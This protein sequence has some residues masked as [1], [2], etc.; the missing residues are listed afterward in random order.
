LSVINSEGHP[1]GGG[2]LYLLEVVRLPNRILK[3]SIRSSETIN[4]LTWEEEACFYRLMTACDDYGCFD[5][6]ASVVRSAL[7]P[8]RVDWVTEA[9]VE[10]WLQRMVQV[11]LLQL[12]EVNGRRYLRLV[13]WDSH[14]RV[15]AKKSRFP[16][17]ADIG[18]HLT[19]D[20]SETLTSDN[21]SHSESESESESE[22]IAV[23]DGREEFVEFVNRRLTTW[24]NAGEK[25]ARLL[26]YAD[27][28]GWQALLEAVKRTQAAG[29]TH[30][31]YCEA[32]C[33]RWDA[34]GVRSL[35]DVEAEDAK[36][37]GGPAQRSPA[38]PF[39]EFD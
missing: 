12:Y 22:S 27:T 21:Y 8:L 2:V 16:Q 4:A 1:K 20:D 33:R 15:R 28:I 24:P 11:G 9:K 13:S 10:S 3:E 25:Y 19:T 6:R 39:S 35:A 30:I 7:Y 14:Q 37:Q 18:G 23:D 38:R 26:T 29:K 36:H 17:P 32:I 31:G 5:G 34:A